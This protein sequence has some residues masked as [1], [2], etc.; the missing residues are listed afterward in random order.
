VDNI[1]IS[2]TRDGTGGFLNALSLEDWTEAEA[3]AEMGDDFMPTLDWVIAGGETGPGARPMHPDWAR[4]L[5]DQCAKAGVPFFFKSWG[6]WG[7]FDPRSGGTHYQAILA[8][9]GE[10]LHR[11]GK[12]AAGRLLDGVE[13]SEFPREAT[14][15]A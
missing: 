7:L 13:H 6:E 5:R 2:G 4:G 15:H 12:K 1:C 9:H 10:W 14:T 3:R 11:C 8:D